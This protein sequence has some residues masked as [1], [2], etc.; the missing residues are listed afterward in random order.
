MDIKKLIVVLNTL[1]M[2]LKIENMWITHDMKIKSIVNMHEIYLMNCL[3]QLSVIKDLKQVPAYVGDKI[4]EMTDE[5]IR[6][7]VVKK[8][9]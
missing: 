8:K 3:K 4:Q 7:K 2:R 1:E 6:R 9:V 5:L